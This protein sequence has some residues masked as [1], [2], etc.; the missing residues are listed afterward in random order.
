MELQEFNNDIHALLEFL[1][2]FSSFQKTAFTYPSVRTLEPQGNAG[3]P[4]ED[5][6]ADVPMNSTQPIRVFV[7]R[8]RQFIAMS[9][10]SADQKALA[11]PCIGGHLEKRS[12]PRETGRRVRRGAVAHHHSRSEAVSRRTGPRLHH[13]NNAQCGARCR[14]PHQDSPDAR[15]RQPMCRWCRS[16]HPIQPATSDQPRE[17]AEGPSVAQKS[18][19]MHREK[20]L[21]RP[22]KI[23]SYRK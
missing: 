20:F 5:G 17:A 3:I 8:F 7:K 6:H 4:R 12:E 19:I 18:G 15:R 9:S 23:A 21:L 10:W 11:N 16:P 1:Q 14:S 13:A 2:L 22:I